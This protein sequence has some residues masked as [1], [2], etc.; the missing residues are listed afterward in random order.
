MFL[1]TNFSSIQLTDSPFNVTG[2]F[3]VDFRDNVTNVFN[4]T[5]S[6]VNSS[7]TSTET[8]SSNEL[9]TNID[10]GTIIAKITLLLVVTAVVLIASYKF[11][12]RLFL[13]YADRKDEV[14]PDEFS[15]DEDSAVVKRDIGPGD[16]E[17]MDHYF[18]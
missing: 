14:V 6:A 2:I 5:D 8:S 4:E 18:G 16:Y 7:A 1:P 10:D 15:D 17:E 9:D 12:V 13:G 11:V 3:L